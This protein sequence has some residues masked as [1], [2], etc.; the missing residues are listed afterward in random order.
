MFERF[1]RTDEIDCKVEVRPSIETARLVRIT[2]S[3]IDNRLNVPVVRG[4]WTSSL[5]VLTK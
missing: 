1:S 2:D 3:I 5:N 4:V